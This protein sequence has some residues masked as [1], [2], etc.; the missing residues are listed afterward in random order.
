MAQYGSEVLAVELATLLDRARPVPL[1]RDCVR[2][3]RREINAR[4]ARL[5]R[6]VGVEVADHGLDPAVGSDL[7]QAAERLRLAAG[8]AHPIPLTDQVR[9]PLSRASELASALR[10][11][12]QR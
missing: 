2:V 5:T 9:L 12:A 6:A 4:I 1:L 10:S 11:A 3:E 8:H 7:V